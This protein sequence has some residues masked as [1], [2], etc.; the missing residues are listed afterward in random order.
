MSKAQ[1]YERIITARR[2]LSELQKALRSNEA[3]QIFRQVSEVEIT[4][5]EAYNSVIQYMMDRGY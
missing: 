1:C 5:G 4:A 3:D 2:E